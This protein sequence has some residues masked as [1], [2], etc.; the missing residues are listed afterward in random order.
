[1]RNARMMSTPRRN[2]RDVI[3]TDDNMT[4]L[5][6]K[7]PR[8]R[9]RKKL[10]QLFSLRLSFRQSAS[11]SLPTLYASQRLYFYLF[12]FF[13]IEICYKDTP[14]REIDVKHSV[15]VF[16]SRWWAEKMFYWVLTA[17]V[18]GFFAPIFG[19]IVARAE[20]CCWVYMAARYQRKRPRR[21]TVWNL[22]FNCS[23]HCDACCMLHGQ[24]IAS[25]SR[26]RELNHTK[27]S[28][29]GSLIII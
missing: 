7:L 23:S 8:A 26:W 27:S 12:F 29:V 9:E 21:I 18:S 11:F 5:C 24:I 2:R 17:L 1:M 3:I 15:L 4:T 13:G 19:A 25:A 28:N 14:C 10:Q 22:I 6:C 20:S 16:I